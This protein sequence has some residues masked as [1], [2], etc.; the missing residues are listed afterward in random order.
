MLW[1]GADDD[2]SDEDDVAERL[3]PDR[4]GDDLDETGYTGEHIR[5]RGW[6]T[7]WILVTCDPLVN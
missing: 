4:K 5:Q 1:T 7:C 3:R 2:E 6:F